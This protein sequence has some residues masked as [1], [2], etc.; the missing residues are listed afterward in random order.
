[1]QKLAHSILFFALA[2][3]A[4]ATAQ[5]R[6]G[7]LQTIAGAQTSQVVKVHHEDADTAPPA[8]MLTSLPSDAWPVTN[9][10]KQDVYDRTDDKIGQILDVMV[11]HGGKNVAIIIGVGG[12]LGIGEKDVAVPFDSVHFKK[13]DNRW[14]AVINTTKEMLR[15]ARGY[16]YD[17]NA[18][19]WVPESASGT[20]GGSN[21]K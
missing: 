3:T 16:K 13:K 4:A 15:D 10:Y 9:W 7:A 2:T 14:Q 1:M 19:R 12:F 5:T 8:Q 6:P 18:Q 20:T 11:D 17:R 21:Q